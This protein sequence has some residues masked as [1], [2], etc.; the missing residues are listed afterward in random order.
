MVMHLS[1]C[2]FLT[3]H[4]CIQKQMKF[5]RFLVYAEVLNLRPSHYCNLQ[6]NL[7]SGFFEMCFLTA[8]ILWCGI[9]CSLAHL[10]VICFYCLNT[11]INPQ[12]HEIT[13]YIVPLNIFH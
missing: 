8:P 10:Y 5:L 11:S 2:A 13:T 3:V 9:N 6:A 7:A 12:T 1:A 4:H